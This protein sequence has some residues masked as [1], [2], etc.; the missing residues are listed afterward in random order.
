MH[1]FAQQKGVTLCLVYMQA[2]NYDLRHITCHF[3]DHGPVVR[4]LHI[5]RLLS[6][7]IFQTFTRILQS[8]KFQT[9]HVIEWE[10]I[11]VLIHH[12]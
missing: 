8:T 12:F 5:N 3:V 9:G 1:S 10:Y 2:K 7:I 11:R 4:L 6:P